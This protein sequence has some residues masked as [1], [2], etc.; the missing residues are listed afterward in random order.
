M[1]PSTDRIRIAADAIE[2]EMRRVGVWSETPPSD[3]AFRFTRAF[4][5]DTM[6]FEQ[7]LQ[8]VFLP[9]VRDLLRSGGEFPPR[10]DVGVYAVREFDGRDE[11]SSLVSRLSEFDALFSSSLPASDPRRTLGWK[12]WLSVAAIAAGLIW[13]VIEKVF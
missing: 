4:G 1:R 12:D 11:L 2:T 6:A 9:R 8:F 5:A 7:W 3:A 13:I 10:S